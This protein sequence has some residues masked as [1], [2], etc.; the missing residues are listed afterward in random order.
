MFNCT[1]SLTYSNMV[2]GKSSYSSSRFGK[3]EASPHP[4]MNNGVTEIGHI[5][6]AQKSAAAR[7]NRRSLQNTED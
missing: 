1:Y 5:T 6:T 2:G 4:A 7:V 3:K